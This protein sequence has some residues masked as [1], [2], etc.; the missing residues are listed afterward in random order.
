MRT[1]YHAGARGPLSR[2]PPARS[3]F[4]TPA[5]GHR[6]RN[7]PR[8]WRAVTPPGITHRLQ[9]SLGNP[10]RRRWLSIGLGYNVSFIDWGGEDKGIGAGPIVTFMDDA[11]QLTFGWALNARAARMYYGVGFS[12]V[13]LR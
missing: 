3:P 2:L 6:R 9:F 1:G 12:V 13:G 10:S 11:L 5:T 8:P 4:R 7:A